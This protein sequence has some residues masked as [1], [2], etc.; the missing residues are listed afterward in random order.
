MRFYVNFSLYI[1]TFFVYN[2]GEVKTM[3]IQKSVTISEY[4]Q[5]ALELLQ[6]KRKVAKSELIREAIRLLLEKEQI[7]MN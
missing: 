2:T 3:I 6:K 5:K 4:E 7:S 1:Y